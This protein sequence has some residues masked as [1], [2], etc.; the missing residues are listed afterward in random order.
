M[1]Q[2]ATV[3]Y[4]GANI[5]DFVQTLQQA[6]VDTLLDVRERALSRRK[7]FSKSALAAALSIAGIKYLHLRD[8]G[9]PKAGREA[10]RAGKTLQF[11]RIFN[12]H[13]QTPKAQDAL[14]TALEIVVSARACLLCYERDPN[15]C[16]RQI[17]AQ[18]LAQR[19][20]LRVVHLGVQAG[21]ATHVTPKVWKRTSGH[22]RQGIT[23]AE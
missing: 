12:K 14:N 5:P 17:V 7:G 18:A 2:L 19:I 4:E 21:T 1:R 6:G 9:D 10:A 20:P 11:Q 15:Q 3:G 8:L 22:T 16:H 23:A 13:L